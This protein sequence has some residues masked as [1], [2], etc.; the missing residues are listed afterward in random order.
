MIIWTSRSI[1]VDDDDE[2]QS[3]FLEELKV[4]RNINGLI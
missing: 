4:R 2:D 1:T 3:T